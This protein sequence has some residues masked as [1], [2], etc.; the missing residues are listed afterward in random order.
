MV[1]RHDKNTE[2]STKMK[3]ILSLIMVAV[4]VFSIVSVSFADTPYSLSSKY[5]HGG[6]GQPVAQNKTRNEPNSLDFKATCII[7]CAGI[8]DDDKEPRF[9]GHYAGTST[10]CT[11]LKDIVI[12]HYQK[13]TYTGGSIGTSVDVYMSIGSNYLSD[14]MYV[15]GSGVI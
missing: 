1:N 9:S 14:Y 4:M 10:K 5:V 13:A 6:A 11:I 8:D 12:N 3:K 15:S 7:W 2:R